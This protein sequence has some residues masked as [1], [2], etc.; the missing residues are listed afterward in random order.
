MNES[1]RAALRVLAEAATPG[2]W[3]AYDRD[4]GAD[5]PTEISVCGSDIDEIP[6]AYLDRGRFGRHADA[7]YIAAVCPATI[8][9]LLEVADAAAAFLTEFGLREGEWA[10]PGMAA[11]K[12]AMTARNFNR[13]VA[14]LRGD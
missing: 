1:E 3:T 9:H 7:A 2:P 4:G 13:L 12:D 14:A 8:L 11:P 6:S 5:H 10:T